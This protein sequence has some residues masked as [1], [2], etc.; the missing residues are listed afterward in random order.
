[1]KPHNITSLTIEP[2]TDGIAFT[3]RVKINGGGELIL[4]GPDAIPAFYT[5]SS[6]ATDPYEDER[7]VH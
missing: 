2:D 4:N 1:M 5:I 7:T 6:V 3:L